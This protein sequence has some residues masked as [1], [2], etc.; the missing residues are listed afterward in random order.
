MSVYARKYF[1]LKQMLAKK[2]VE[3]S[4]IKGTHKTQK[5]NMGKKVGGGFRMGGTHVYLWL[6]HV[7]IWQ[8]HHN[9]GK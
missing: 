2:K 4:F 7:Y 5:D 9:I 6:I 3:K 8:N 1:T